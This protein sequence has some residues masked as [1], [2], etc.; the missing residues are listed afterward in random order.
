MTDLWTAVQHRLGLTA[1]TDRLNHLHDHHRRT[2][3]TMAKISDELNDISN[4]IT[5]MRDAQTTSA[6][7]VRDALT[8]LEEKVDDLADGDL[9]T[10]DQA[11]VD[12]IKSELDAAKT[13][14]EGIDDGYEPPIVEPAPVPGVEGQPAP[15]SVEDRQS[16]SV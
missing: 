5:A 7:N 3:N 9:S 6:T 1:I 13:A 14:A 15:G 8:R 4:R 2:E 16:G 11:K 12:A 10:D